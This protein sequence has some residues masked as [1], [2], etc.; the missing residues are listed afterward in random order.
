M[1]MQSC[2]YAIDEDGSAS[3]DYKPNNQLQPAS[4]PALFL[5]KRGTL[6]K[7]YFLLSCYR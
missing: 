7:A 2:G 4:V 3:L 1:V 5:L 6:P